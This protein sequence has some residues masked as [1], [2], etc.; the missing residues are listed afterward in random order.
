M[1]STLIPSCPRIGNAE[2]CSFSPGY[3]LILIYV[4]MG[5]QLSIHRKICKN[6]SQDDFDNKENAKNHAYFMAT[7]HRSNNIFK[8]AHRHKH[9][10]LCIKRPVPSLHLHYTLDSP[11]TTHIH[12]QTPSLSQI[13]TFQTIN[14]QKSI[15]S[16]FAL[17]IFIIVQVLKTTNPTPTVNKNQNPLPFQG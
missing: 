7:E 15:I 17:K 9:K 10:L 6:T 1:I 3:I 16:R 12:T 5:I 8:N 2:E 13:L 11:W 4:Q 14:I